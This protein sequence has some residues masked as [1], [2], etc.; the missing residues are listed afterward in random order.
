MILRRRPAAVE[1]RDRQPGQGRQHDDR[2]NAPGPRHRRGGARRDSAQRRPGRPQG[3]RGAGPAR[4]RGRS[5]A[6]PH[7]RPRRPGVAALGA[8]R[9]PIEPAR[10]GASRARRQRGRVR[11]LAA[12]GTPTNASQ[13]AAS[14]Q[15]CELLEHAESLAELVIVE[16]NQLLSVTDSIPPFDHRFRSR[17]GRQAQRH[18][19]A[20]RQV[21]S[22]D[23]RQRPRAPSASS[24]RAPRTVGTG[25][26]RGTATAATPPSDPRMATGTGVP[27]AAGSSEPLG[28]ADGGIDAQRCCPQGVYRRANEGCPACPWQRPDHLLS[29]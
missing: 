2:G 10:R 8:D 28:P 25:T 24:P 5:R 4:R 6:R 7:R 29:S 14:L 21:L 20:R 22:E 9:R 3:C 17:V 26:G 18:H 12:G 11:L 16:S 27:L 1:H 15:M 23:R 13:L 19:Q